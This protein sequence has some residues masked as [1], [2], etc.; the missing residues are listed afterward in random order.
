M[1]TEPGEYELRYFVRQDRSII[2]RHPIT[3]T[4]VSATLEAPAEAEAGATIR[5]DWTGPDYDRDYI[6]VGPVGDDGYD[7][8][9]Y[10]RGGSPA[11]LSL[12]DEPGDY[13]I[14][15][16]MRQD[17]RVIARAPLTVTAP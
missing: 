11:Q 1:P 10:T 13:E 7:S 4:D 14:R 9:A 5:V 16:Y 12:P 15:Y 3:V 17:R 8:Y 6:G 2:A